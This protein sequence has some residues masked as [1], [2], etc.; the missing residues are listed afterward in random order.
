[1]REKSYTDVFKENGAIKD[2]NLMYR[3]IGITG[4]TA[5]ACITCL[6]G[7]DYSHISIRNKMMYVYYHQDGSPT[8]VTLKDSFPISCLAI[9]KAIKGEM[10]DLAVYSDIVDGW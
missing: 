8:A 7:S 4:E 10:W 5:A 1:M 6:L 3:E 2:R 9:A